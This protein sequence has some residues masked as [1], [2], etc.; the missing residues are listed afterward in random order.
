MSRQVQDMSKT[1]LYRNKQMS[2]LKQHPSIQKDGIHRWPEIAALIESKNFS[3]FIVAV[4][5][6]DSVAVKP[7]FYVLSDRNH[8]QMLVDYVA[9]FETLE[10]D[11]QY[12]C[13]QLQISQKLP[14]SNKSR[15]DNKSW[16]E[17][18]TSED[19]KFMS[20][21]YKIDLENFNYSV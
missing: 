13:D 14:H 19:I 18:Y 15:A 17:Y 1:Y 3:E 12:I 2:F 10:E 4:N 9:K 6:T 8:S 11:W 20:E 7:Q 5:K 16:Q 21:N